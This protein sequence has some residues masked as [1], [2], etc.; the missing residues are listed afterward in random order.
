[1]LML[2]NRNAP[3][4]EMDK[5]KDDKAPAASNWAG[6]SKKEGE[7]RKQLGYGLIKRRLS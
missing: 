2:Q 5:G 7:S 4:G 6:L 1:L 3:V